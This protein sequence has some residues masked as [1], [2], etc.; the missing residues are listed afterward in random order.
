MQAPGL[1]SPSSASSMRVGAGQHPAGRSAGP[2]RCSWHER[3][4]RWLR[5]R[6]SVAGRSH[7]SRTLPGN[8]VGS[9]SRSG[10]LSQTS[11]AAT[12]CR[13]TG[14]P[15][16]RPSV[17]VRPPDAGIYP[18]LRYRLVVEDPYG[19]LLVMTRDGLRRQ[20]DE[21]RQMLAVEHMQSASAS[22]PV[23]SLTANAVRRKHRA[24]IASEE[25]DRA[26]Q[27][28]SYRPSSWDGDGGT[29][30]TAYDKVDGEDTAD[31][32]KQPA[33]TESGSESGEPSGDRTEPV[34]ARANAPVERPA[35]EEGIDSAI[36]PRPRASSMETPAA[37]DADAAD[38]RP[39]C[40]I[41]IQEYETGEA[42]RILPRCGHM[43]HAD[44]IKTWAC[45]KKAICPMCRTWIL[46]DAE[47]E[48]RQMEAEA[49]RA[50]LHSA[51]I[52]EARVAQHL[53]AQGV[54]AAAARGRYRASP[55]SPSH[56]SSAER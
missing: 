11:A 23:A 30:R 38:D 51:S 25:L 8:P 55:R 44:C 16:Y 21:L 29:A 56:S 35:D 53:Q 34:K 15:G 33:E 1:S 13:G 4:S 39:T 50:E 27:T 32:G 43:F 49:A 54:A 5:G 12:E 2:L 42:V 6:V 24:R 41:C 18:S 14:S 7:S 20:R 22:S 31:V 40:L 48:Q 3:L 19:R 45:Q 10:V 9:G 46:S 52:V 28:V 37:A 36:A 26:C 47:M 17:A